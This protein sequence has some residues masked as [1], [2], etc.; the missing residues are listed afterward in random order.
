MI[1]GSDLAVREYLH[2]SGIIESYDG[3]ILTIK[4]WGVTVSLALMG[5]AAVRHSRMLLLISSLSALCFLVLEALF[6][7]FA[8]AH[9]DRIVLFEQF[10][11]NGGHPPTPLQIYSGW[12]QAFSYGDFPDRLLSVQTLLPN[13][14]ICAVA[15]VAF[16]WAGRH[17]ARNGESEPG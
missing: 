14:L 17:S 4:S 9:A 16:F 7:L 15:L 1:D 5:T 11:R 2:L 3:K 13:G 12:T 6:R 8:N 10:F